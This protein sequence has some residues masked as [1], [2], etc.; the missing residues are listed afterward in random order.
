MF[1]QPETWKPALEMVLQM[2]E[3]ISRAIE[4]EAFREASQR[5]QPDILVEIECVSSPYAWLYDGHHLHGREVVDQDAPRR[6]HVSVRTIVA[7]APY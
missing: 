2:D 5:W 7:P 4:S 3:L 6:P 1:L